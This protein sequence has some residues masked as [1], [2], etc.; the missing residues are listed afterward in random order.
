MKWGVFKFRDD[1]GRLQIDV[2]PCDAGPGAGP[3][4]T[5]HELRR[6][7]MCGPLVHEHW[8]RGWH[9]ATLVIHERE[10]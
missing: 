4:M 6:P 10:Q 7:C 9:L 3:D 5:T 8:E 1:E 2:A